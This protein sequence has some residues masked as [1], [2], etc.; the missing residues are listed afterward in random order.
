MLSNGSEDLPLGTTYA[1]QGLRVESIGAPCDNPV[2]LE[3]LVDLFYIKYLESQRD[4]LA[5]I[6][7]SYVQISYL[8]NSVLLAPTQYSNSAQDST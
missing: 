6:S 8:S 7:F 1:S 4:S 2:S 5:F 3:F